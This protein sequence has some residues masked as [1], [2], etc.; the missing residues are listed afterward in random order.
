MEA[1]VMDK[2]KQERIDYELMTAEILRFLASKR[3]Y[4]ESLGKQKEKENE[5]HS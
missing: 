4:K 2:S 1:R 3:K 5:R